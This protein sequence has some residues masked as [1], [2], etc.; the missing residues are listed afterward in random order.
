MRA[1]IS[2]SSLLLDAAVSDSLCC[3]VDMAVVET[4]YIGRPM[5]VANNK[6]NEVVTMLHLPKEII[7]PTLQAPD[8]SPDGGTC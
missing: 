7:Y 3:L 2:S 4:L 8:N 5:T 6:L 1:Q